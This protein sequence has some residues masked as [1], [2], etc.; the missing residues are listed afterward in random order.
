L[1]SIFG[2]VRNDFLKQSR[3]SCKQCKYVLLELLVDSLL[4]YSTAFHFFFR[5][6]QTLS[7]IVHAHFVFETRVF[8]FVDA[9]RDFEINGLTGAT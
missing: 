5:R 4:S 8:L 6:D 2:V 1:F 7:V 3:T 9:R